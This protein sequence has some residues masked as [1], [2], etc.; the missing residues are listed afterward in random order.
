MASIRGRTRIVYQI[1]NR[2][3]WT[4]ALRA[5][6][7]KVGFTDLAAVKKQQR[8]LAERDFRSGAAGI[9]YKT[10]RLRRSLEFRATSAGIAIVSDLKYYFQAGEAVERWWRRTGRK[11]FHRALHNAIREEETRQRARDRDRRRGASREELA[12]LERGDEAERRRLRRNRL[13]RE[14][15]R[16][17][18]AERRQRAATRAERAQFRRDEIAREVKAARS[19]RG[20]R[21]AQIQARYRER[22]D[23]RVG[24]LPQYRQAEYALARQALRTG[25]VRTPRGQ[26]TRQGGARASRARRLLR[27]AR[28]VQKFAAAGG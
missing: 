21:T 17:T 28:V 23:R 24:L 9:P 18:P 10:G 16:R 25:R 3:L 11:R 7:R 22:H 26:A 19:R 13:A 27:L 14:N 5:D 20:Q 15:R 2:D 8:S 4:E 6:A 1:A 12:A